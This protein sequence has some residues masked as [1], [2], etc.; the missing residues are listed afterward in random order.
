MP[1]T[2]S[3]II[4]LAVGVVVA[5]GVGAAPASA[6]NWTC[7]A[8]AV[9]G[10]VLTVPPIEPITANKGGNPCRAATAGGALNLPIAVNALALGAQTTVTG[11][12]NDPNG[13]TVG[14]TGGITDLRVLTLPDLPI[15]LPLDQVVRTCRR[16][17][18]PARSVRWGREPSI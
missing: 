11:P 1:Q 18:D 14:A 5:L 9:R 15:Q 12:A 17:R 13:Q 7:E 2:K 8:S 6:A 3:T 16:S 4:R 10:S